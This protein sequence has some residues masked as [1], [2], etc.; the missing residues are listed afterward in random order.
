MPAYDVDLSDTHTMMTITGVA[1]SGATTG[2]PEKNETT[3]P[4]LALA[5]GHDR[6]DWRD[7]RIT[8]LWTFSAADKNTACT[9]P[10]AGRRLTCTVEVNDHHGGSRASR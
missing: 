7:H 1:E 3:G 6:F 9:S 4:E 10:P 5:W 8:Q 2:L